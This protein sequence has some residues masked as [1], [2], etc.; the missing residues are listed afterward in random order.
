MCQQVLLLPEPALQPERRP[1]QE[2]RWVRAAVILTLACVIPP[3]QLLAMCLCGVTG[4][5]MLILAPVVGF[6]V[7]RMG[8]GY[9][10]E[11]FGQ[12]WFWGYV[13]TGVLVWIGI[14][15]YMVG[16]GKGAAENPLSPMFVGV[17]GLLVLAG[18]GLWLIAALWV[19]FRQGARAEE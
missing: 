14:L 6:L 5:L 15:K 7:G 12:P 11:R 9:V 19:W 3:A 17:A 16:S 4:P 13:A 1:W 2:A 18:G 10:Y 8:A